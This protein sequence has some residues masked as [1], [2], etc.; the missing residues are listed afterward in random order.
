[1]INKGG[2]EAASSIHVQ[3]V[4]DETA[5]RFVYRM[6][7]Q[8]IWDTPVTPFQG[9]DTVSPFVALLATT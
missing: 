3:F 8:P 9:S 2:I 7:G 4:T 1:M 5:F 6:D